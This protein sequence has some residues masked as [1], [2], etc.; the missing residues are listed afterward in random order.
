[1]KNILLTIVGVAFIALCVAAFLRN[2]A[3]PA[4]KPLGA[5]YTEAHFGN[6]S[7]KAEISNTETARER[8]LSGRNGLNS[9]E[10]MLFVFNDPGIYGFWMKDMHFSL[11]IVGLDEEKKVVWL[12]RNLAPETYPTVFTPKNPVKYVFELPSGFIDAHNID[13]GLVVS[14]DL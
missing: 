12:E 9:D 13:T 7:V 10:S 4:V 8:G 1:M 3:N 14:F 5:H 11:D 6:F 2:P